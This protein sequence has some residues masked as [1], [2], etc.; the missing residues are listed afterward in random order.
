MET[1]K[2]ENETM[3]AAQ[4]RMCETRRCS[5]ESTEPATGIQFY[6][7][8]TTDISSTYIQNK[9]GYYFRGQ[10]NEVT[11]TGEEKAYYA[12]KNSCKNKRNIFVDTYDFVNLS[13][14]AIKVTLYYCGKL[15]NCTSYDERNGVTGNTRNCCQESSGS[16]TVLTVCPTTTNPIDYG[17]PGTTFTVPAYETV[18]GTPGGS[19][20]LDKDAMLIA[21]IST[22]CPR[23]TA[24]VNASFGWWTETIDKCSPF[25]TTYQR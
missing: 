25:E 5:E 6:P 3:L 22:F 16:G 1:S 8:Y 19:I 14:T 23:S 24:Y 9:T 11:I 20:A 7:M 10:G 18:H 13:D 4:S 17:T 12:L 15:D 21:E 2:I